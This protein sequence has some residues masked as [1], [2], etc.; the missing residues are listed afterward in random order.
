M[1]DDDTTRK[2]DDGD[3]KR[4]LTRPRDRQDTPDGDE[5]PLAQ[6]NDSTQDSD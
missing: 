4:R 2:S 1:N 3:A 5:Q 6:L